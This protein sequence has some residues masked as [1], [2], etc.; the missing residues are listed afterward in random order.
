MTQLNPSKVTSF[1][2]PILKKRGN[3]LD[4][5]QI[6]I[7]VRDALDGN[8]PPDFSEVKGERFD[9]IPTILFIYATVGFMKTCIDL[10]GLH[11]RDEARTRAHEKA[12]ET[13]VPVDVADEVCDAI[14]NGTLS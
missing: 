12:K 7:A 11:N 1:V 13:K 9:W 3:V 10:Y 4:Q 14:E 2:L 8:A 5:E 6:D